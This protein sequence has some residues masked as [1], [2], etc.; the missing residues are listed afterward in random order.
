MPLAENVLAA[1]APQLGH[2][3]SG[4]SDMGCS[5]SNTL[6]QLEHL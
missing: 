1:G 3:T 5:T 6:P 4:V 2:T